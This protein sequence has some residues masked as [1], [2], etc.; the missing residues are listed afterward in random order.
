[1]RIAVISDIHANLAALDAVLE[2]IERRSADVTV[3]LGDCCAGP[4]W[5]R[6]TFARL[7][8]LRLPTVR[9]NH[10][11]MIAELPR[12]NLGLASQFEFDQLLPEQRNALGEL[13]ASVQLD[14]DILAVHGTPLDDATYLLERRIDSRFVI[15]EL[16][17]IKERLGTVRASLVLCGHSHNQGTLQVP[18]G[19]LIV[20]PGSV[21]CPVFAD[22]PEARRW[23][24]RSPHARYAVVTRSK[25]HWTTEMIALSYDWDRAARCALE[26]GRPEWARAYATGSTS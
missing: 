17:L 11:R 21:G 23:D 26:N 14:G 20:N 13:P 1:M 18:G 25:G 5:P 3:N 16:S 8:S 9:G 10:D 12:E 6:E 4:L 2:D 15:A 24:V 7:E 22:S 19:P